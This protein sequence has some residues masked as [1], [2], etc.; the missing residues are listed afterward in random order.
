MTYT[1]EIYNTETRTQAYGF[2]MTMGRITLLL[3]PFTFSL[4][5]YYT[6]FYST[7]LIGAIL[8]LAVLAVQIL[9]ETQGAEMIESEEIAARKW[10]DDESLKNKKIKAAKPAVGNK[11]PLLDQY[12]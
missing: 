3:I 1:G 9:P 8:L 6:P 4:W 2:F 5:A 7:H 11:Q 12:D 10:R